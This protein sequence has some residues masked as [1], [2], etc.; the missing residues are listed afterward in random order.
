M[1]PWTSQQNNLTAFYPELYDPT[2]AVTVNQDG[3]V[4]SGSGNAYDGLRRAGDG[5]PS[6]QLS[7]V[8]NGESASVLSVP[9]IGKRGFY[10]AQKVFAPRFGF[11]YDIFGNGY[12]AFRGGA[13]LFYDTPQGNVAYTALNAPPYL[14][15]E[16]VT[17]G[18]MDNLASYAGNASSKTLADMYAV[19][20]HEQRPYIY[21]Y[22]FGIQQQLDKAM[23]LQITY[24]GNQG[25]HLLHEPDIN[26]IDPGVEDAAFAINESVSVNYLRPYK[27]YG[28]I[29]QYRTDADSNYN[30]LQANLN[31]RVGKM[32]FTLA[33]TWSKSLSTSSADSEVAEIYPFSKTYYYGYTTF[34]RRNLLSGTYIVSSPTF[35]GHNAFVRGTLGSWMLSGTGRY[36]D[37]QRLTPYGE[38]TLGVEGRAD[39]FGYPVKYGHTANAWVYL[40]DPDGTVNFQSPG[41]GDRGNSPIGIIAGPNYIDFDVSARKTFNYGSRYHLTANLDGFNIANHPNFNTP[42]ANTNVKVASSLAANGWAALAI[43]SAN[44]PRNV[45]AGL[46]LT[47]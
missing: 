38:D 32:R 14:Q 28:A 20:P 41:I 8:P 43:T 6:D 27:G 1:T 16:T 4:V 30:G 7:R 18:S 42:S 44:R 10:S 33:Y 21:Q 36:Q 39:Y 26:D 47:F 29:W 40:I 5:V 37:G 2:Q 24:V 46:R 19:S 25:R 13:G 12:T 45:Q 17:Y 15:S 35:R 3:T 23:F 22:N 31:R 11:A 9:T 34:D